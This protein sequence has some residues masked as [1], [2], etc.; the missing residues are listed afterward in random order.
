MRIVHAKILPIEGAPI[1]DG[2]LRFENGVIQELGAMA[3]VSEQPGD[4]DAQGK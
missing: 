2:Y 3:G 1:E 4:L